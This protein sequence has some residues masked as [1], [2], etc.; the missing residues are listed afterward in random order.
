[1]RIVT[2]CAGVWIE[3]EILKSRSP[4]SFVTPC[5]GVWIEILY[6]SCNPRNFLVTPCAGVW[7]EIVTGRDIHQKSRSLPARE[8]G[9]K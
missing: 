9:L 3:I 4:H 5:A 2:P 8:C 6:P 7:I 1:M